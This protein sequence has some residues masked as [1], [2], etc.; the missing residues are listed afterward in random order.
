M[1]APYSLDMLS[2]YGVYVK[3]VKQ[4]L[5]WCK[6][7][8]MQYMCNHSSQVLCS[9]IKHIANVI[10]IINQLSTFLLYL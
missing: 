4:I 2:E 8:C 1:L 6:Y 9:G 3:A 7:N 10:E 5:L